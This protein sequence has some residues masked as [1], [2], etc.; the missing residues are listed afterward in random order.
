M[1]GP[2]QPD[3]VQA[4]AQ[5]HLSGVLRDPASAPFLL[6]PVGAAIGFVAGLVAVPGIIILILFRRGWSRAL[7]RRQYSH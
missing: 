6:W 1:A 2:G 7:L 3:L 4:A 5:R